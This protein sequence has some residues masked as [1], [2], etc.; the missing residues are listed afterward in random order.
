MKI[1]IIDD[2]KAYQNLVT[3]YLKEYDTK[4][5][6]EIDTAQDLDKAFKQIENNDYDT[7]FLDLTLPGSTGIET[8]KK[9]FDFLEVSHK[10]IPIIILTGTEDYS[11]G[12]EA[13]NLG[14]TDFLV[15]GNVR[16]KELKRS[17][18]F[19]TYPNNIPNR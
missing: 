4:N 13:F 3:I 17:L 1:L 7:V 16:S 19:A 5:S 11:I 18:T 9:M 8:V 10:N 6:L 12:T 14:V 2:D 15:K